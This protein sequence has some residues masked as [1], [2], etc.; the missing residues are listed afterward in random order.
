MFWPTGSAEM[1]AQAADLFRL[2]P[3]ADLGY[4]DRR[5]REETTNMASISSGPETGIDEAAAKQGF[6][7]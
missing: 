7:W 3:G 6:R 2:N 4:L 5:I 1:R